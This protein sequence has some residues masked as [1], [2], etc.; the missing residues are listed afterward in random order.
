MNWRT[1]GRRS[2]ERGKQTFYLYGADKSL[3]EG[4]KKRYGNKGEFSDV[5][6]L[7][8]AGKKQVYLLR[9]V[10]WEEEETVS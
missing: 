3:E 1:Q 8:G 6:F 2:Q 5:M 4:L 10:A 9:I 7:E